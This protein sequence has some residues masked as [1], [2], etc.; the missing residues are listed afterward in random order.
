MEEALLLVAKTQLMTR[1]SGGHEVRRLLYICTAADLIGAHRE[2][3][4][5]LHGHVGQRWEY[6]V[7]PP[8]SEGLLSPTTHV[9]YVLY[10]FFTVSNTAL[11]P[12][13]LPGHLLHAQG[14]LCVRV[15]NTRYVFSNADGVEKSPFTFSA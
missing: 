8:L 10:L 1:Q 2:V 6:T 3:T 9:L 7:H 12:G 4:H 11:H 5:L 13:S 15:L 14:Q